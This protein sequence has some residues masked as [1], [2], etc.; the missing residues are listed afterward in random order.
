M[1]CGARFAECTTCWTLKNKIR[2]TL[3]LQAKFDHVKAYRDH[4]G[5]LADRE[6]IMSSVSN[7]TEL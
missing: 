2:Q 4:V 7:R 6:T 5:A 3:S 1:R